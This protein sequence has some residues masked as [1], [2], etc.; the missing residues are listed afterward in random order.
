VVERVGSDP[1][2]IV[3]GAGLAGLVCARVV[4]AAGRRVAVLEASD[5]VGG[6]VQTDHVDG[7]LLD[8][9]FQVLL[10]AYPA[11]RRWF[12]A[13]ALGL[14]SFAPGVVV[15]RDGRSV[16]LAD[17]F[18]APVSAARSLFSP[19]VGLVDSVRLL[20]WRR[21]ILARSG[22]TVAERA[23]VTTAQRLRE[24]GFSSALID[25]FFRPFLAGTFFDADLTTSSRVTEL[26]FRCFFRG[27]VAV[28]ELGMGQLGIQLAAGLPEGTVQLRTTVERIRTLPDGVEVSA[29][30]PAGQRVLRARQVVLAV[31]APALAQLG[32]EGPD[33]RSTPAGQALG[34][35]AAPGR[36]TAAI[37][38]AAD[39]SPTRGRP[40]LHLGMP[41]EGPIATLATM[42]DVAAGYAPAGRHL[43]TVSTVGVPTS[44]D[45]QLADAVRDQA[46]DWFGDQAD[47]W[48][49]LR[50]HRIPYAQPRQDP[51][52]LPVLARPV[53]FGPRLWVCGDHRDTG[54][55]QGALVSGRRT[56][57]Q[58]L[59][60]V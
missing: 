24:I 36:G 30:G 23:Q 26:V 45:A 15:H 42:S 5:G 60:T 52:D 22:R 48:Q 21:R 47:T 20:G 31:A 27:D 43:V 4:H 13:Q 19:T 10:T 28:P 53:Q 37:H 33:G 54:S 8:R 57:Q 25:G 56:A 35:G 50:V 58:L 3:I 1:E 44:D 18:R 2:V 6:R 34:V 17:P 41:G 12:D 40:D 7:F 51:D 55:I 49:P 16:R 9:G 59:A 38:F 29:V 39:R 32:I 46:R 14:R 11:A